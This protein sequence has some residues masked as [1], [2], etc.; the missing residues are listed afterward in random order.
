MFQFGVEVVR[1][2]DHPPGFPNQGIFRV[3]SLSA[4]SLSVAAL[5]G[6]TMPN[7]RFWI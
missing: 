5:R 1:D 2:Q 4:H 6:G 7:K 3:L